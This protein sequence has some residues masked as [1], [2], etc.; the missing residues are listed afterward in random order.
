[1][2]KLFWFFLLANM[3]FFAIMQWGV[4]LTVDE[5]ASQPLPA[6]HEEKISLVKTPQNNQDILSAS[7]PAAT[8]APPSSR[9]PP[10]SDISCMEWG[11]FSGTD[12]TQAMQALSKLQLGDKLNQRQIEYNIGYWVYIPPANDKAAMNKKIA[13]IKSLGITEYFVVQETGHFMNAISLGVFKTRE[14]AQHFFDDLRAKGI[15]SAQIGERASKL[16]TTVFILNR[17]DDA[18]GTKLAEI[19]NDFPESELKKVPCALTR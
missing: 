4:R 10:K 15:R 13:Q 3:I 7:T 14:A 18:T 11:E 6:L 12:L 2:K 5:Q 9:L 19:R 8:P 1:M 16:K 17:L